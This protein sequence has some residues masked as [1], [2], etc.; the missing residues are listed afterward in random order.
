MAPS[1]I[2]T[3]TSTSTLASVRGR[4]RQPSVGL[5]HLC[6]QCRQRHAECPAAC[7]RRLPRAPL[8]AH[9]AASPPVAVPPAAPGGGRARRWR[10]RP[11]HPG[12]GTMVVVGLGWPGRPSAS[13]QR[14]C[15]CL[16]AARRG[17]PVA[18]GSAERE[19]RRSDDGAEDAAQRC[20]STTR[21]VG[22]PS[23]AEARRLIRRWRAR[24]KSTARSRKTLYSLLSCGSGECWTSS[25]GGSHP[26]GCPRVGWPGARG[27]GPCYI[28]GRTENSTQSG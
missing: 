12:E 19:R 17:L 3:A 21:L 1:A 15:R 8:P 7:R 4:L 9:P 2:A 10:P 26:P 6:G 23:T 28:R 16:T 25:H 5:P 20:H 18:R 27:E 13:A 22:P 24:M 14:W 11:Q